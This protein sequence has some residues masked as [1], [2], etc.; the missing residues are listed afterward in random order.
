M[1]APAARPH[2]LDG[3]DAPLDDVERRLRDVE[4]RLHAIGRALPS[5]T[6][7]PAPA[8]PDAP[9]PPVDP[10]EQGAVGGRPGA[11]ATSGASRLLTA[12]CLAPLVVLGLAFAVCAVPA[13]FGYDLL[14]VTGASMEPAVQLGSLAMTKAQPAADVAVG[15]V[16][17]V[18]PDSPDRAPFLH[19]V[20]QLR[21]EGD[22]LLA[23]THG[24][25]N[26]GL[27]PGWLELAGEVPTLERS[28]PLLG[29]LVKA[30]V[31][32]PGWAG[33]VLLP[34]GLACAGLLRRI[35]TVDE[36]E[37]GAPVG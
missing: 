3:A 35:W 11:S 14:A 34:G 19:R 28:I 22:L 30:L 36:D 18:N 12:I 29:Y 1:L 20:R 8:A 17:L 16:I 6:A 10:R 4:E 7:T 25:A 32:P 13:V 33:L 24:D 31:T 37:R 15:D 5:Q 26:D 9:P 2:D 21:T 23:R 27:D